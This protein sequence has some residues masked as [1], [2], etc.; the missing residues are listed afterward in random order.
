[1]IVRIVSGPCGI[2]LVQ[3]VSRIM[4]VVTGER[5]SQPGYPGMSAGE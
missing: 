5:G 3:K 1:M 4:I 2:R